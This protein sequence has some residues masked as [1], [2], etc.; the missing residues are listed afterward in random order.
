MGNSSG[1]DI[2]VLRAIK[3]LNEVL[4]QMGEHF[5][6]Y[7]CGG[8]ALI[9]L[10]YSGRK[11]EDIDVI[12]TEFDSTLEAASLKV[13]KQ[14][15]YEPTWLNN[16]VHDLGRRLGRGWKKKCTVLFKGDGVTLMSISRQDLINSKFHAVVNRKGA[17]IKDLLFLKPNLQELTAAGDYA[18]AQGVSDGIETSEVFVRYWLNDIKKELGLE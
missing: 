4:E 1:Q 11:T 9:F 7:T 18:I 3:L 6:L 8:A 5:T 10:G 12:Q 14:L 13:A 16:E 15:G 17:D 2:D